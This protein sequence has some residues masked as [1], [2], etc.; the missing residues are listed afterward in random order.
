MFLFR[1]VRFAV[2]KVYLFPSMEYMFC[3]EWN[4]GGS[5]IDG[6]GHGDK[7]INQ[8]LWGFTNGKSGNFPPMEWTFKNMSSTDGNTKKKKSKVNVNVLSIDGTKL[9]G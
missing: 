2:L 6:N 4:T 5:S 7:L 1:I 9:E 8:L 3:S